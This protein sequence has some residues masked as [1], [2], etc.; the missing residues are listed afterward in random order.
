MR[1]LCHVVFSALRGRARR[2]RALAANVALCAGR[3]HARRWQVQDDSSRERI[4]LGALRPQQRGVH[5][6]AV[7]CVCVSRRP[8]ASRDAGM[9]GPIV[10]RAPRFGITCLASQSILPVAS[11]TR[12]ERLT[13]RHVAYDRA[14]FAADARLIERV[15][16]PYA[17]EGCATAKGSKPCSAFRLDINCMLHA[18]CRRWQPL[19]LHARSRRQARKKGHTSTCM[20]TLQLQLSAMPSMSCCSMARLWRMACTGRLPSAR[21]TRSTKRRR[22]L[23]MPGKIVEDLAL[24]SP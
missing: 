18:H 16:T 4:E 15:H 12:R 6:A 5:H 8:G 10:C 1:R 11:P 7:V 19:G 14:D 17:T 22:L 13:R 20:C 23:G 2:R 21:A 3:L 9:G 24:V